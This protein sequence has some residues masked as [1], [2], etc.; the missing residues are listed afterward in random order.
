MTVHYQYGSSTA[1]RTLSCH[2]WPN[3]AKLAPQLDR[4]SDAAKRGTLLHSV[5]EDIYKSDESPDYHILRAGLSDE[6]EG[7]ILSAFNATEAAL[8]QC[9]VDEFELERTLRHPDRDD[10]G[11]TADMIGWSD[12]DFMVLDYKFG[13]QAVTKWDQ[14]LFTHYMAYHSEK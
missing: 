4:E 9:N 7:A 2:A 8:D 6:D 10:C 3:I 12:D 1:T 13:R 14:F 5:M 11:G